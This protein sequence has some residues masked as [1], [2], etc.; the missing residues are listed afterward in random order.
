MT[1]R[2]PTPDGLTIRPDPAQTIAGVAAALERRDVTCVEVVERCLA[3]VDALD[4]DL[5]AWVVVDRD[6]ALRAAEQVDEDIESSV[7]AR[8]PLH[9][10]PIGVKD[11]IDVKG[12][13]TGAGFAPWRDRVAKQDAP[14]VAR[15]REAGAIILGKTVTTQFACFDPPVTVNP[16]DASR[17]PG[18]SSSGSAVAVATGM[19]LGTV[20]TQTGGSITRPATYCGVCGM[21]P[22]HG[23]LPMGGIVPVSA[24]LDH[25]GPIARTVG[26]CETMWLAMDGGGYR[27]HVSVTTDVPLR[28]GV[29]GGRFRDA[30]EADMQGV[31]DDVMQRLARAGATTVHVGE[32]LDFSAMLAAHRAIMVAE[33]AQAHGPTLDAHPNDVLSGMTS[34]IQEGRTVTPCDYQSAVSLRGDWRTQVHDSNLQDCDV[35][36]TTA[37]PGVAPDT[38][39]T[40]DP[41][42]NAPWSL[43]GVPT[44]SLPVG[45]NADGL[46]VGVQLIGRAGREGALCVAARWVE[47][48]L[49][50]S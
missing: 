3:R 50:E 26:D 8:G 27:D 49:R 18:G 11:I 37:T 48:V 6:G 41:S 10:I 4:D 9:G 14:I 42:F 7:P 2:P 24:S 31:F 1:D 45:L 12:L 29:V 38:A 43:L 44:A 47:G 5:H 25:V 28:L 15:L 22:T 19:C 39:T 21:K 40:G 13:P 23:A 36:I 20:G 16:W 33:G 35:W 17:T 32:S 30:C 34:F 46:P